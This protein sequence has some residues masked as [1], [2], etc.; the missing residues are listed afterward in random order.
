MS[1][2]EVLVQE[3]RLP[4]GTRY[5]LFDK[6]AVKIWVDK[7]ANHRETLVVDLVDRATL[8]PA[9]TVA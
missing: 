7:G 4:D 5:K 3:V 8:S 2:K 9:D 6:I 1:K